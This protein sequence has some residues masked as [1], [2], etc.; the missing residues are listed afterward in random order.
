RNTYLQEKENYQKNLETV[1]YYENIALKNADIITK[2]A[3]EQF[4][5]GEINYLNWVILMNNALVIK[6]QYLV[7]VSH[8][9]ESIIILQS[10][11]NK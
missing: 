5:N 10:L 1:D 7:S 6:D 11:I 9:N 8:L 2:T 3:D 4:S